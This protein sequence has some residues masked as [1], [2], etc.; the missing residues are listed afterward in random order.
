[1]AVWGSQPKRGIEA[2]CGCG[3][4]FF[5]M[6]A[7][8]VVMMLLKD[9][10]EDLLDR[11]AGPLLLV[12]LI[13]GWIG[14]GTWLAQALVGQWDA[15]RKRR[16]VVLL[17]LMAVSLP[18]QFALIPLVTDRWYRHQE[19]FGPHAAGYMALTPTGPR[20]TT[21]TVRG[22]CVVVSELGGVVSVG[23]MNEL[24]RR[25][26]AE[27][28]AE[29]RS[30]VQLRWTKEELANPPPVPAGTPAPAERPWVRVCRVDVLDAATGERLAEK[31][32][33]GEWRYAR[34]KNGPKWTG[35]LNTSDVH[36][37]LRDL[38]QEPE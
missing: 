7:S 23:M 1:M 27:S 30:V 9:P 19:V 32:F 18:G 34:Y 31:T 8:L 4:I 24:P 28:P 15:G 11:A 22:R 3:S 33:R 14:G 20:P 6:I 26:R 25:L 5:C 17:V 13:G 38:R 36:N 21:Q 10:A 12:L 37:Y 35:E 2:V 29:V 16:V